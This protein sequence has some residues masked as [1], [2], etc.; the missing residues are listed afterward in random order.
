MGG[1]GASSSINLT[2][3]ALERYKNEHGGFT[4]QQIKEQTEYFKSYRMR[5]RN[6]QREITSST[7]E[8]AQRRT[9][10]NINAWFGRG[11]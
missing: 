3:K 7:Y 11:M 9:Q 10:R 8:R 1:R 6:N 4:P 5:N 2:G